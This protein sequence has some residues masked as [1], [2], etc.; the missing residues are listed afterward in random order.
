MENNV[1]SKWKHGFNF[2]LMIA[3]GV[4]F[5]SLLFYVADL[6]INS[7]LRYFSYVVILVGLFFASKI[8]RDKYLGGFITFQNSFTVAFIAGLISSVFLT[9][10]TYVFFTY[11]APDEIDE[12][13]R[14]AEEKML[15]RNPD[16]TDEQIDMALNV[17][18]KMM[19]PLWMTIWALLG[20]AFFSAIFALIISIFVKK[21]EKPGGGTLNQI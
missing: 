15:E 13:M 7:I 19:S 18:K 6:S 16:M 2:G 1:P 4:I 20:N 17:S 8:Y 21:E 14:I 11:I 3:A 12:M 5:F 10:F 9:I